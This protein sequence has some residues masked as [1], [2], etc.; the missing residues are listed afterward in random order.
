LGLPVWRLIGGQ[1][2]DRVPVYT[3]LGFGEMAAVYETFDPGALADRARAVVERGYN[4]FKIVCVPYMNMTISPRDL[5]LVARQMATL[6][7]TV[8][9][10]VEIMIDMHGRAGSVSAAAAVI[11]VLAPFR[12]M[13]VEEPIQPGDTASL[14]EIARRTRVPIAAGERLVDR[15]EFDDVFRARAIHIAQPDICHVGGISEARK[16]AAMAETAGIGV[17]PHNPLGP[18][19]G[20]AALHFAVAT[21]NFVIQEEMSGAV[22]WY[23]DVVR[24]PIVRRDGYWQVPEAPGLGVEVDEAVA[25]AHPFAQEVMA[26]TQAVI[27]DGTVVDW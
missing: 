18:I 7:E 21:P 27:A 11:D 14:A 8:G 19:A 16:I 4:A 22:P 2:R 26:A 13:F 6:R 9:D 5:D 25:A 15:K 24:G 17:A 10:G 12:P 1:V 3:H 20:A 23:D